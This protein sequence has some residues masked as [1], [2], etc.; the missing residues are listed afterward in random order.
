M[1]YADMWA[2]GAGTTHLSAPVETIGDGHTHATNEALLHAYN[3]PHFWAASSVGRAPRLQ[4]GGQGF[5]P[6]AVHQLKG[7]E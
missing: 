5:D 6:L 1:G 3:L 7:A 2:V 4:R